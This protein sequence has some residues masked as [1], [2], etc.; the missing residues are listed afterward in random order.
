M[1]VCEDGRSGAA[2]GSR[3]TADPKAVALVEGVALRKSTAPITKDDGSRRRASDG[4]AVDI[5]PGHGHVG[6]IEVTDRG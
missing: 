5:A 6:T 4:E 1:Q 2:T 3:L